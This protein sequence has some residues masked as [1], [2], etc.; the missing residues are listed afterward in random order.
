MRELGEKAAVCKPGTEPSPEPSHAGTLFLNS[1]LQ[2]YEKEIPV[3][4]AIQSMEQGPVP[5]PSPRPASRAQEREKCVAF[6]KGP[7]TEARG[8]ERACRHGNEETP[9]AARARVPAA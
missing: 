4:W 2:N 8:A 7:C 3:V 9:Q 5:S 6:G 1:R